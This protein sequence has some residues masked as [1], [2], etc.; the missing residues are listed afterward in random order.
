MLQKLER[1]YNT[2]AGIQNSLSEREA[3]DALNSYV[4]TNFGK[5]RIDLIWI[6]LLVDLYT[7]CISFDRLVEEPSSMKRSSWDY[8]ME[9]SQIPRWH[10]R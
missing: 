6:V 3:N 7:L 2:V 4:C 8:C 1:F 5:C 10:Q 9:S